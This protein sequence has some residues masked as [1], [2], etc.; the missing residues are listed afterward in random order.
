VNSHPLTGQALCIWRYKAAEEVRRR[1]AASAAAGA[2]A[3][4][5]ERK[6]TRRVRLTD[7]GG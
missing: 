5:A 6:V 3:A 4:A 7:L 2:A 1:A